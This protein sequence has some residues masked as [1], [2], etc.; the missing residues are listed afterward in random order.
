MKICIVTILDEMDKEVKQKLRTVE[1]LAEFWKLL[2]ILANDNI[3][4][5]KKNVP[6]TANLF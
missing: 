6:K 3:N 2:F 4:V 1:H 5:I